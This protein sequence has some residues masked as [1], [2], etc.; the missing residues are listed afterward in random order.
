M[1]RIVTLAIKLV[2]Q[3]VPVL[4]DKGSLG[5]IVSS[6]TAIGTLYQTVPTFVTAHLP[7]ILQLAVDPAVRAAAIADNTDKLSTSISSLLTLATRNTPPKTVF[8]NIAS[9]WEKIDKAEPAQVLAL[10]DIL[11]RTMRAVTA[12]AFADIYKQAFALLMQVLDIR[13][14]AKLEA[15]QMLAVEN[16]A[17]SAYMQMVLK[18][19]EGTFRPLFLRLCDWAILDMQAEADAT[20][21][22]KTTLFRIVDRMLSQLKTIA[23]PYFAFVLDQAIEALR[24]DIPQRSLL[25]EAVMSSLRRA[26][27]HD[28]I[29]FWTP[30]RLAKLVQPIGKRALMHSE[31]DT[32]Y[33]ELLVA[34]AQAVESNESILHDLI[35]VCLEQTR[36]EAEAEQLAAL[37]ALQTLWDAGIDAAMAGHSAECMPYLVETLEAGGQVARATKELL[38]RMNENAGQSSDDSEDDE[39]GS[40]EDEDEEL[41]D[42]GELD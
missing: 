32:G 27:E 29:G 24:D 37:R 40:E 18:L 6:L 25:V 19:N 15:S 9:L 14:Q 39:D 42:D 10:L 21:D 1:S 12:V 41:D 20:V 7:A 36:S 2:R 22:R 34:F 28:S 16:Q 3:F 13:R 26:F 35:K 5:I 11:V 23:L 17:I 33:S 38:A 4:P 30:N 8:A 31:A